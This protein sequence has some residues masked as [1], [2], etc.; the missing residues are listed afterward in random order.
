MLNVK[1]KKCSYVLPVNL[2]WVNNL[3]IPLNSEFLKGIQFRI[4]KELSL[5]SFSIL[6]RRAK[7]FPIEEGMMCLKR[8]V[9]D[10]DR[11][12]GVKS[13]GGYPV[14]ELSHPLSKALF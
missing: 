10:G 6:L 8:N 1:T 3:T 7:T 11:F 9:L 12:L 13:E 14:V 2:E 5:F 4:K